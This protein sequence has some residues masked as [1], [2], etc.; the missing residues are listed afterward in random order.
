M[1]WS[2]GAALTEYHRLGGLNNKKIISH[3]SDGCETQLQGC[4]VLVRPFSRLQ[5]D[6]LLLNPYMIES[7]EGSKLSLFLKFLF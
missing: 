4:W 2:F 3:C 1:S 6:D 7:Q 5:A